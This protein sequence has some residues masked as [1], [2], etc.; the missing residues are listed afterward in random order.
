MS[1]AGLACAVGVA[2]TGPGAA[3]AQAA[4]SCSAQD[5]QARSARIAAALGHG[6]GVQYWGAGYDAATLSGAPHGLLILEAAVLGATDTADGRERFFGPADMARIARPDRPALVYLNLTEMEPWRDYWPEGGG[7]PAF[8][9][10]RLGPEE[11]L[12]AW[13]TDD[14]RD[15][16]LARVDRLMATG[17]SGLFLDDAL[18]Y[19]TTGGLD[20]APVDAPASVPEAAEVLMRLV[21]AVTERMRSHSC[22][23]LAVVNNA[24]F[25]GRD[26]G[27]GQA[28]LFDRYRATIDGVLVESAQ[29]AADHP[30]LHTALRE[31]YLSR[32]LPVLALDFAGAAG[33]AA[34][35]AGIARARGYV[36]YV[37]ENPAF[38]RLAGAR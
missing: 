11:R 1:V 34:D 29:G 3:R 7:D 12:G 36:P 37:A 28:A 2:A 26:A 22:D 15:M 23:A 21:L 10:P 19:W 30:D 35:L 32:N 27:L 25:V 17:A 6:F 31:D 18:H 24:V 5:A 13:W 8:A 33:D 20:R 38:D 4:V 14:W 16:L 9:G